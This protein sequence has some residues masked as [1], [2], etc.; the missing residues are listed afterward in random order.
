MDAI[1][2]DVRRI[3][4]P[5]G[6]NNL[7][8]GASHWCAIDEPTALEGRHTQSESHTKLVSAA[9]NGYVLCQGISPLRGFGINSHGR[10]GLH[11]WLKYAAA[12]RL[13]R[14]Q[15]FGST[16]LQIGIL[17]I[18]VLTAPVCQAADLAPKLA[19]PG[20]ESWPSFRNGNLQ[21]GVA[22]TKLPAKLEKLWVHPAGDKD[23]MIKSTAAIAGGMVY[24]ASLN[25]EVFCI[26]LKS[27][28][29]LWTYKSRQLADP[30][31]FIPGFKAAVAVTADTVYVGDEEGMFHTIERGTG[32]G[33]WTFETQAEIV[34]CASFDGDNVVF[35]SHDNSLYCLRAADGSKVWQYA[36]Q[37]MVNCSP[38]IVGD[39]TFV[40]GCDEHLRVINVKTGEQETDIPLGIYLIASPAVIDNMLYVGTHGNEMLAIDWKTSTKMWTYT[41]AKGPYHSSAA[42]NDKYVVVG[43]QDKKLYC[44]DRKTGD[45]V[46]I[47][48]T[49]GHVDSSPVIVGDRVFV[50]SSDGNVYGINLEDGKEVWRFKDPD[51]R[52]F[53]ASPA[54]GEGCLV[55]GSESNAGNTYCFG[56]K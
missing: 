17:L 35:G 47:F 54:V 29:R 52:A 1:K 31:A 40:T 14:I 3:S 11:P 37:G 46:W 42:V 23:G 7:A 49:K 32:K 38:A 53:T 10:R 22:T 50:G 18:A 16:G 26:D 44:L 2:R 4:A 12:P 6:R 48:T 5:E 56:A 8:S 28:K 39:R 43:A 27:G 33:K 13:R 15:L 34:S 36:T 20:P 45:K 9:H 21:L 30:K 24:T 19:L 25:G 51:G 55:I 41:G